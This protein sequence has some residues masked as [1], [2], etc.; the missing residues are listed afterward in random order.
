M[1]KCIV[2]KRRCTNTEIFLPF[3]SDNRLVYYSTKA[4]NAEFASQNAE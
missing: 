1:L 4:N 2:K 3:K